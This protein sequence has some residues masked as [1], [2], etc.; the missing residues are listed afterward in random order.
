LTT[1]IRLRIS[2]ATQSQAIAS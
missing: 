2:L 1:N